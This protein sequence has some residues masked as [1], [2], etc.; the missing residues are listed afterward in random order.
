MSIL[1]VNQIYMFVF[2]TLLC[3]PPGWSMKQGCEKVTIRLTICY[4]NGSAWGSS[5][6]AYQNQSRFGTSRG[7]HS[8]CS[9]FMFGMNVLSFILRHWVL[10]LPHSLRKRLGGGVKIKDPNKNPI[11][12]AKVGDQQIFRNSATWWASKNKYSQ[13]HQAIWQG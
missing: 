11:K 2:D 6:Q 9:R 13:I 5:Q 12:M 7:C 8:I 1:S 4:F 3:F 10:I